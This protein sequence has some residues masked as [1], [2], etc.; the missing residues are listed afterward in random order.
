MAKVII[1]V[2]PKKGALHGYMVSLPTQTRRKIL[3]KVAG[4]EAKLKRKSM[5]AQEKRRAGIVAVIRRLNLLAT[6]NKRNVN[7][8]QIMR[9]D[10]AYLT[11]Q[12]EKIPVRKGY[13]LSKTKASKKKRTTKRR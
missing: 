1:G 7:V 4:M 12:K 5:S 13:T 3:M 9:S 10:V 8:Y 2:V 11:K 6:Y